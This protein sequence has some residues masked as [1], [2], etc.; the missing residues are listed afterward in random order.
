VRGT[1]LDWPVSLDYYDLAT[2]AFNGKIG[3]TKTEYLKN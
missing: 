2:F 3:K 1:D